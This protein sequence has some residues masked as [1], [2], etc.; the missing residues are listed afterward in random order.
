MGPGHSATGK[1]GLKVA[2]L[3]SDNYA[4]GG[5]YRGAIAPHGSETGGKST[6]RREIGNHPLKYFDNPERMPYL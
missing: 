6:G 4:G 3:Q 2:E 5:W 1:I